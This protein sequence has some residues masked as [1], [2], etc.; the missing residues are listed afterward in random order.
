MA[1][2][3]IVVALDGS[4]LSEVS[5]KYLPLLKPLG[6]IRVALVAVVETYDG[7]SVRGLAAYLEREHKLLTAYLEKTSEALARQLGASVDA[8]VRTGAP[9]E[10]ILEHAEARQADL[11]ILTTH[12]RSG[13]GRWTIGSVADKVVR[14]AERMTLVIGPNA[15]KRGPSE[16][17]RQI[18]VP[19]DGSLLAEQALEPGV[20]W[21]TRLGARLHL[22]RVVPLPTVPVDA[23]LTPYTPDILEAMRDAAVT[24]LERIKVKAG[25]P[26]ILTDV[27]LGPAADG[28]IT[29]EEENGIDLVVMTSHGRRGLA[30]SVLGSVTDRVLHGPA[31]VL[32]V[33]PR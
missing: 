4:E 10:E 3:R 33:R 2:V 32:I 7:E 16:A 20:S 22:V 14:R 26:D 23:S 31:P 17:I 1:E 12:G 19:L 18:L 29:Y 30:R 13:I 6:D 25:L 15:A 5:L 24:Y 21:G 11:L 28:L 9:D 8:E 27:P